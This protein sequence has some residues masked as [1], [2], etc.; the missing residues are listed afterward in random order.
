MPIPVLSMYSQ[1][2]SIRANPETLVCHL[3]KRE[4]PKYRSDDT[5]SPAF[6]ADEHTTMRAHGRTT[7]CPEPQTV[8]R[9]N[10]LSSFPHGL[11]SRIPAP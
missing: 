9:K 10:P 6:K 11:C 2:V 5:V 8:H 3:Y 1:L 7:P 4:R